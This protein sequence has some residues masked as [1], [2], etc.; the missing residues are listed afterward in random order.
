VHLRFA[1][2][3][4]DVP[5]ND[6]SELPPQGLDP[7]APFIQIGQQAPLV[8]L[9]SR[10]PKVEQ[11]PQAP[12]TGSIV[13]GGLGHVLLEY[14]LDLLQNLTHPVVVEGGNGLR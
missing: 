5:R 9:E 2:R 11:R 7:L 13:A 12:I 14:R 10:M 3:L 4:L 1:E 6:G 8:P